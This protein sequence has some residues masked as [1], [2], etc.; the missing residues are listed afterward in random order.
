MPTK[1]AAALASA[2]SANPAAYHPLRKNQIKKKMG[3]P[4]MA[5]VRYWRFRNADAP[6]LIAAA[7]STARGVEVGA[8]M[9]A[10]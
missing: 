9:T 2:P 7:I 3:T 1:P 8:E 6:E 5:T 4:T 10:R